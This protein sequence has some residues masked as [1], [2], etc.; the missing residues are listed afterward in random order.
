[1][2]EA[3]GH[4]AVKYPVDEALRSITQRVEEKYYSQDKNK[5]EKRRLCDFKTAKGHIE[6]QY[7]QSVNARNCTG[8]EDVTIGPLYKDV[9]IK[10]VMF[11]NGVPD[12]R[13]GNNKK[14]KMVVEAGCDIRVE[15]GVAD[16]L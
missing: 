6:Y 1:M 13:G 15:Q 2:T 5:R 10:Q 11:D 4:E 16:N 9:Y 14:R 12:K 7:K 3:G 8:R